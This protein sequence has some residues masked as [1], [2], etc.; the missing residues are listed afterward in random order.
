[1]SAL[2]VPPT[3]AEALE[4]ACLRRLDEQLGPPRDLRA[5]RRFEIEIEAVGEGTFSLL[6]DDGEVTARR[7]M[8]RGEPLLSVQIPRAG[9]PLVRRLLENAAAAF[10]SA[11]ELARRRAEAL[12]LPARVWEGMVDGLLA[13]EDVGL[14]LDLRGVGRFHFARGSLEELT[15][16]LVLATEADWL[17][18]ALAGAG[19]GDLPGLR[20]G[21]ERSLAPILLRVFGPLLTPS[22]R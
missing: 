22:S 10:P 17:E 7:G 2:V 13:L 11:P 18:R 14:A 6:Y 21:G 20:I 8:A 19:G 15:R 1:M 5:R 16:E 12:A 4:G 9:W 3:L